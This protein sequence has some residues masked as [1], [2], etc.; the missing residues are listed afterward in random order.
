LPACTTSNGCFSKVNQQGQQG[1]YPAADADWAAEISLDLDMVS[2]ICPNCHILLVEADS[3]LDDDLGA[4][5]NEAVTLGVLYVSNSYGGPDDPGDTAFDHYYDHPGVAITAAAGDDGYGVEWP[6][7]SPYVTAVG[8]TS[9]FRASNAR[10]FA[11]GAWVDTG[12]GCS[13]IEP[14]PSWQTDSGCPGRTVGDVS[15][16]AD[17]D[18]GVASYDTYDTAAASRPNGWDNDGGTSVSTP[19]IAGVYALAGPPP[20]GSYPA[21]FPYDHTGDFFDIAVGTN[22]L[23]GNCTPT[24]LCNAEPGYDGPTGWGTPNG[25]GGFVQ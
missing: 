8:G 20:S 24:Y 14:K 10:G 12:S 1:S 19:I 17:P 22:Y 2:A 15:A 7:S 6:A 4:S 25:I 3:D 18:P 23:Y 16:V 5:E 9:L 13:Q 21:Q 11:E